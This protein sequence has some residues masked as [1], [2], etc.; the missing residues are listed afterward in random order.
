MRRFNSHS[1][2]AFT[3]VELMG[4]VTI[5]MVLIFLSGMIMGL[6]KG[7]SDEEREQ[8][9]WLLIALVIIVLGGGL[10]L[11]AR[12]FGVGVCAGRRR[13]AT[14]EGDED[15]ASTAEKR[16]APQHEEAKEGSEV[17]SPKEDAVAPASSAMTM[18]WLSMFAFVSAFLV[19]RI[20]PVLQCDPSKK[21]A[22]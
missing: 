19:A 20:T 8:H 13:G 5:A 16:A 21:I 17:G 10:A 2:S 3:M 1:T 14:A 12:E 15:A 11:I 6:D 4:A 9:A 7:Q 22:G 18:R